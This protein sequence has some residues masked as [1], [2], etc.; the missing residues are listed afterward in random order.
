MAEEAYFAPRETGELW[1]SSPF[2]PA[3]E[4][5]DSGSA[6][7][8]CGPT[9]TLP[10][11]ARAH[12]LDGGNLAL[13]PRRGRDSSRVQA[14]PGCQGPERRGGGGEGGSSWPQSMGMARG[15]RV[16]AGC[17]CI[18]GVAIWER[19][20]VGRWVGGGRSQGLVE[21]KGQRGLGGGLTRVTGAD[22]ARRIR[23]VLLGH[24]LFCSRD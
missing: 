3:R 16:R 5:T 14:R 12:R 20:T 10:E 18:E 4:R 22:E 17:K 11:V 13:Q 8:R 15:T 9:G 23:A 7:G 2:P 21:Q 24:L 19:G 6:K 1:S